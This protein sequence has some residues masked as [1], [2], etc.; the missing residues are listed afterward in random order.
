LVKSTRTDNNQS[1]IPLT[2]AIFGL[3]RELFSES[4]PIKKQQKVPVVPDWTFFYPT[5]FLPM[6]MTFFTFSVAVLAAPIP[7]FLLPRLDPQPREFLAISPSHTDCSCSA[8][9][10]V[11]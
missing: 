10:E 3:L 9:L 11:D 5:S 6:L 8:D 7:S 1:E 2:L 4:S